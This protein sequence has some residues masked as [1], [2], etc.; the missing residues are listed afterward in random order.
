MIEQIKSKRAP[1]CRPDKIVWDRIFAKITNENF[2]RENIIENDTMGTFSVKFCEKT[3]EPLNRSCYNRNGDKSIYIQLKDILPPYK[4]E[5]IILVVFHELTHRQQDID[6]IYSYWDDESFLFTQPLEEM[7]AMALA[8][9]DVEYGWKMGKTKQ[10]LL[11]IFERKIRTGNQMDLIFLWPYGVM[12]QMYD[13]YG[14]EY[15]N[16]LP[17]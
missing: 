4:H 1:I 2:S 13:D 16:S 7:E 15:I 14:H 8:S 11:S 5:N 3:P 9:G 10:Q 17:N 12:E 6:K